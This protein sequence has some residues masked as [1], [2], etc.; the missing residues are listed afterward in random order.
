MYTGHS[1]WNSI[2]LIFDMQQCNVHIWMK[3]H[4]TYVVGINTLFM[5]DMKQNTFTSDVQLYIV[6]NKLMKTTDMA[7]H[8][9]DKI[10]Y[11]MWGSKPYTGCN[12]TL[13]TWCVAILCT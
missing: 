9:Y 5:S 7:M 3:L 13:Y 8:T 1:I 6:V 12:S 11:T 4:C 10:M 2:L